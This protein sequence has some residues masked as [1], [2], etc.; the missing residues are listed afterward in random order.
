VEPTALTRNVTHVALLNSSKVIATLVENHEHSNTNMK[1]DPTIQA[2]L[3][4]SRS[5]F[6]MCYGRYLELAAGAKYNDQMIQTSL[7][8]SSSSQQATNVAVQPKDAERETRGEQ[9]DNTRYRCQGNVEFVTEDSG[10]RTFAKLTDIS[11]GG[12]YVEM[13]ATSAPG[14]A[15]HLAIEVSGI[16]FRVQGVVKTSDPCLGMGILFTEISDLDQ[17]YLQ[18]LLLRLSG[19]VQEQPSVVALPANLG[20]GEVIEA[21]ASLYATQSFVT[22]DEF[23]Y[24]VKQFTK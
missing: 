10:V 11:F 23:L 2:A 14:A 13:T 5:E 6:A 12:C 4:L 16:R 8:A 17:E 1:A 18:K 19:H 7:T 3:I 24:T 22:R 21:L 20:T 15:V 9:R